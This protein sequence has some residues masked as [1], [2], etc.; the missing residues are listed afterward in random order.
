VLRHEVLPL[1]QEYCYDEPEA[2]RAIVGER[3]IDPETREI[4]ADLFTPGEKE[5]EL[6]TALAEWDPTIIAPSEDAH[7][8]ATTYDDELDDAADNFTS[9]GSTDG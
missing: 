1:L 6:R 4:R 5:E 2:L 7:D 9:K 3:F 8:E